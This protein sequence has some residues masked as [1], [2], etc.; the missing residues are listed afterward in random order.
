MKSRDG[1][2]R[3]AAMNLTLQ[4][5]TWLL[6]LLLA[7]LLL[8]LL[9]P[10]LLPFVAGMAIA[11]VLDPLVD[12]V[13]RWRAPRWLA[14]TIVLVLFA[15]VL[16]SAF[17]LV[18]PIIQEQV[19][20]LIN[21]LPSYEEMRRRV[22]PTLSGLLGDVSRQSLQS[23]AS[24][25]GQHATQAASWAGSLLGGIW[26]GGLALFN[27]LSLLVITPVVAFYLLRD[28]DRMVARIDQLL[29]RDQADTVREAF[30]DIDDSLAGFVRGQSLVCLF[31]GTFYGVGLTLVG[32]DFGLLI[33]LIAGLL[34]FIP[35][36]GSI[37]GFVSSV[38][39]A[40]VQFDNYYMVA[41]VAG[42]FFLGQF[43]EGNFLTP[44][45]VGDRIGL[46]P[47]W[48]IFAL[49]AGGALFGF[50]GVLLAVPA[51]AALAVLIRLAIRAYL[52]SPS[53][54]GSSSPPQA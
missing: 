4:L 17:I 33:G 45:V 49:L 20:A 12:R 16:V 28:W 41:L 3:E 26:S 30:R 14:T 9:S 31:L 23:V 19:A 54:R 22:M 29:P 46:H 2:A 7:V 44:K 21:A 50:V 32:L 5:R 53:Y 24:K 8:Y 35:Y 34:S 13:E 6:A 37:I 25:V 18:V 1:S 10:I 40:L 36:A 43:V 39:I 38:G 51:A 52:E 15:I 42:I 11:Y 47:V 48:I 27:V